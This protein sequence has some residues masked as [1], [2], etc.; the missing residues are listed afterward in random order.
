Q[1][2]PGRRARPEEG[3]GGLPQQLLRRLRP[4]GQVS[5][6]SRL[7]RDRSETCPTSAPPTDSPGRMNGTSEGPP[8]TAGPRS[9]ADSETQPGVTCPW[10][11]R[12]PAPD[13]D[14]RRTPTAPAAPAPRRRPCPPP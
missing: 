1:E 6:L 5:D 7:G 8:Q 4:V 2:A 13:P 12:G 10:P 9:L 14:A 3:V 11:E